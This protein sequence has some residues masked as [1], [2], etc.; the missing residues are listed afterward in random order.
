[1]LGYVRCLVLLMSLITSSVNAQT[2]PAINVFFGFEFALQPLVI[3]WACGGERE[4]DL[5]RIETLIDAFPED[6]ER[7]ELQEIVDVLSEQSE[8]PSNLPQLLGREIAPQQNAR[9]CAAALPL[10]IE[11]LTPEVLASGD[12]GM[13]EDQKIVWETFY[14]IVET[15]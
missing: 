2:N 4:A 14:K 5:S 15:L 1:M 7:A 12:E 8:V 10:N 3:K 13:S 6:A 9:L 11:W